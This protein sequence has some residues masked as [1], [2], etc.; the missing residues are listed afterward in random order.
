MRTNR[1]NEA[2]L[3]RA[4]ACG[5][6]LASPHHTQHDFTSLISHSYAH[7]HPS[8]QHCF[9]RLCPCTLQKKISTTSLIL[10]LIYSV[11]AA[12]T[13]LNAHPHTNSKKI[14]SKIYTS[15]THQNLSFHLK[16]FTFNNQ[17]KCTLF[18]V[19]HI[20]HSLPL[21]TFHLYIREFTS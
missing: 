4:I 19:L 7:S 14:L 16:T 15:F 18:C 1:V 20:L 6:P 13:Y 8:A 9:S 12:G 11:E 10:P 5:P 21:S 3:Y 2:S 17:M